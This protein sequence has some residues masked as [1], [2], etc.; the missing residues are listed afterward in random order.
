MSGEADVE[1]Q[2]TLE[3]IK[4]KVVSLVDEALL[5]ENA[6]QE[7]FDSVMTAF[8]QIRAGAPPEA[9]PPINAACDAF[10]EAFRRNRVIREVKGAFV[11]AQSA[12]WTATGAAAAT[13]TIT[14]TSASP[15]ATEVLGSPTPRDQ[16]SHGAGARSAPRMA[17]STSASVPTIMVNSASAA[18][19]T[20]DGPKLRGDPQSDAARAH[21]PLRTA[22]SA[23][24]TPT[25]P[26]TGA[27]A[28]DVASG[29]ET[30]QQDSVPVRGVHTHDVTPST[31]RYVNAHDESGI[32]TQ[33]TLLPTAGG[34]DVY[35]RRLHTSTPV[36]PVNRKQFC[37][38]QSH[39]GNVGSDEPSG[40]LDPAH[41]SVRHPL[42]PAAVQDQVGTFAQQLR[43]AINR[44]Y[45]FKQLLA[46][47]VKI[48]ALVIKK[49]KRPDGASDTGGISLVSQ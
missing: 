47:R 27:S 23:A 39:I 4:Q 11:R 8:R 33:Q 29:A 6:T 21:S 41:D 28:A 1:F 24:S 9:V 15:A 49:K 30:A 31:P 16:H 44:R 13:P 36:T 32:G 12:P 46:Q 45:S 48:S 43:C 35:H 22:S 37:P 3:G 19:S 20:T 40:L 38:N 14:V 18:D 7:H 5:P 25:T 17:T 34:N 42:P 26:I 10:A 2:D